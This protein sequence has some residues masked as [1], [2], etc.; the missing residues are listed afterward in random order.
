[1]WGL[2]LERVCVCLCVC[3]RLRQWA[4]GW[5]RAPAPPTQRPYPPPPP[6]T[7]THTHHATHTHPIHP[8]TQVAASPF[9]RVSYTEAIEI[10][11]GVVARGE[12]QFEFAVEWGIDLSVGSGLWRSGWGGRLR[13][14]VEW[15][16]AV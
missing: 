2:W 10:L 7:H 14:W 4:V 3:A 6:H 1:M 13:G 5:M 11:E 15:R 9:K 8:P 12:K 16:E